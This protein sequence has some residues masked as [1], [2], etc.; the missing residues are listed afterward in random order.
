LVGVQVRHEDRC[1]GRHG[2]AG[3]HEPGDGRASGVDHVRAA[4]D[5]Q[6]G[7]D[8][9]AGREGRRPS[10]RAEQDQFGAAMARLPE[11][12]CRHDFDQGNRFFVY[13]KSIRWMP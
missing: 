4:V 8:A 1:E 10:G 2:Q 13:R 11:L 3:P 7:R 6:R 9:G 5:D 12:L